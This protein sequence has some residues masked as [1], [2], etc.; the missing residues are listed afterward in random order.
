MKGRTAWRISGDSRCR[1]IGMA[2]DEVWSAVLDGG[3]LIDEEVFVL[4]ALRP[5]FRANVV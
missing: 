3:L 2:V 5:G 4:L 1:Y